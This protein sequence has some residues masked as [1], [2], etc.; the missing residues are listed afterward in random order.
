[1]V[2]TSEQV[3]PVA[4]AVDGGFTF[5]EKE[6]AAT[7]IRPRR[8]ITCCGYIAALLLIQSAAV[9]TLA[10]TVFKLKGPSIRV[11]KLAL[12]K[13]ALINGTNTTLNADV[14]VKNPNF[15]S[16]KYGNMTTTLFYRGAVIGEAR[17]P[18]GRAK[19]RRT[20]R[21]NVTVDIITDRILSQPDL[22]SDLFSGLVNMSSYTRVG[23]RLSMFI[24][25]KQMTVKMNCNITINITS[26]AIQQHKCKRKVKISI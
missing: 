21:V 22:D 2:Q 19:A 1:M 4:P 10:F 17:G 13:L 26:R 25:K 8:C 5:E 11:N 6:T 20:T 14:W 12:E 23:G 7:G 15:A 24:I 9:L 18:P 3:H 16:F